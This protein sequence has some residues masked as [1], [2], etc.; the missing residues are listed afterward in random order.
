MAGL[1]CIA[2][3]AALAI[4]APTISPYDPLALGDRALAQPEA[5]HLFGTD[6]L[7]RDIL[8]GILHGARISLTIGFLAALTATGV[9]VLVGAVAGY[10]GGSVDDLLMRVTEWFLVIPQFFLVL[11]V[12]ALFGP[13]T[14]NVILVI[15]L[16]GWP[17]TARLVRAQFLALREREFVLAARTL[18]AGDWRIIMR[19]ILPNGLAPAIVSGSLQVAAAVLI[20]SNLRFL[21]LSDPNVVSWGGMLNS[22]Q[23]F[24]F[25]AWWT[26]AFP[27][28]AIFVT[29]LGFNLLGD[30]LNDALNPRTRRR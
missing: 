20:E 28:A 10:Y 27:G 26:A 1:V 15:G 30:G 7:G 17:A 8:S 3:M 22:A 24:L 6:D 2:G 12:A 13:R 18:G 9:G 4:L 5:R 16:L 11:I 23:R 14:L 29:V 21:G 19:Q 25:Q